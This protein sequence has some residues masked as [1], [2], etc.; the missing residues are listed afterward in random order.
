MKAIRSSAL[1]VLCAL[2][3]SL[4]AAQTKLGTQA[5]IAIP[6]KRLLDLFEQ[7]EYTW[8]K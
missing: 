7:C 4:E 2:V 3:M 1:L 6:F 8:S 5:F